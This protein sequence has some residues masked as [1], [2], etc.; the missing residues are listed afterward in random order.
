MPV[1]RSHRVFISQAHSNMRANK[2]LF[3]FLRKVRGE[4]LERRKT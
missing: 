3:E 4:I 2:T 1:K